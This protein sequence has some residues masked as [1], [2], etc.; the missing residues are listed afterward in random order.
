MANHPYR[1]KHQDEQNNS[2][3][4]Y[5]VADVDTEKPTNNIAVGDLCY[6]VDTGILYVADSA[7]TWGGTISSDYL[8]ANVAVTTPGT[9][10]GLRITSINNAA[11]YA[12]LW[13]GDTSFINPVQIPDVDYGSVMA[14]YATS[15]A[16]LSLSVED[17]TY[18]PTLS[19]TTNVAASTAYQCQFIRV[20]RT[21][22]VSGRVD[23]DPTAPGAAALGISLPIAS[24][25]G[26][27]EDC[28]GAAAASGI[29]G[30]CAAIRGH[31]A[32]DRAEMAW[33]AADITNQPMY[34]SFSYQVI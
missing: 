2:F 32:G 20:G 1:I 7:T 13:Y 24:N 33:I 34:F 9:L 8:T 27:L 30:Q 28:A 15:P 19:N 21:V 5:W 31:I 22:T 23:V 12:T 4:Q 18:T 6:A 14:M 16:N 29:A 26:A 3:I 10:D 17:G 25:I 11:A